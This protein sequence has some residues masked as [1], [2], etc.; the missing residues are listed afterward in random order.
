ML[1]EYFP[2]MKDGILTGIDTRITRNEDQIIWLEE[3]RP[4]GWRTKKAFLEGRNQSLGEKYV[5]ID[6]APPSKV[7]YS[8]KKEIIN[9]WSTQVGF[10]WEISP[11]WMYRGE[12]G[13]SAEQTF[14][15]TGVQYR[16]GL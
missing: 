8:I 4:D 11:N 14:F 12:L 6:E 2:E 5:A 10:N 7:S 9:A 16:F 1:N 3:T 13:Y 15:M